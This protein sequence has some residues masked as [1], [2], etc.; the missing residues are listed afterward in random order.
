MFT[1]FVFTLWLLSKCGLLWCLAD[2][3][4]IYKPCC[5]CCS[6]TLC[7]L[8]DFTSECSSPFITASVGLFARFCSNLPFPFLFPPF[9]FPS[10]FLFICHYSFCFLFFSLVN[11]L[12]STFGLFLYFIMSILLILVLLESNRCCIAY[13]SCKLRWCIMR[14]SLTDM[15][16]FFS[17]RKEI[18]THEF[19]D[20][21][22]KERNV[23]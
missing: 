17:D 9:L 12:A 1:T 6:N 22:L 8:S 7:K 3:Y 4:S 5:C 14:Q 21:G 10:L 2:F 19:N 20:L 18:D 15:L 11:L 13:F 23:S 16:L